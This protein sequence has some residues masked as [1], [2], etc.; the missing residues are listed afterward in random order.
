MHDL[1]QL[2][3]GLYGRLQKRNP[4]ANGRFLIVLFIRFL[5]FGDG[6]YSL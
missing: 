6:L 4:V 1:Q 3:V 5:L 2:A